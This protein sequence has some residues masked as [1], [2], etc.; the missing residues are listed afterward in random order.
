MKIETHIIS[1]I[2]IA[3]IIAE[4]IIIDSSEDGAQLLADV[5]YQDFD[6]IIVYEKNIT[7][8]F[9]D[10]KTGIA[11]EI[12]QKFSNFRVRLAIIGD[13]EKFQS[14]SIRDFIFESNKNRQIN[15]TASLKESL[16][17]LSR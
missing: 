6:H 11:G 15:F 7:P 3:E 9:F 8:L 10:L 5:Y 4:N 17:K 2:R 16:E 14:K 12:L 1:N 13:F